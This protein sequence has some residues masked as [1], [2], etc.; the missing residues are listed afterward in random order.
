MFRAD[1]LER[2]DHL[3]TLVK[4][5]SLQYM[6]DQMGIQHSNLVNRMLQPLK[7][8]SI[9]YSPPTAPDFTGKRAVD[10]LSKARGQGGRGWALTAM[11]SRSHQG[12]LSPPVKK[13]PTES[14]NLLI[15]ASIALG[16]S[17]WRSSRDFDFGGGGGVS[18]CGGG[19][20]DQEIDAER[21]SVGSIGQTR[22]YAT[23]KRIRGQV[24]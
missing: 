17:A 7:T 5:Y 20:P 9:N 21:S 14:K 13:V 18:M 4:T 2:A 15:F 3:I 24:K 12:M 19:F 10:P 6:C 11:M 22:E 23:S 16:R 1:V 8:T